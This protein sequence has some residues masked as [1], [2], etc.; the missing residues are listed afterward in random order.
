MAETVISM[1]GFAADPEVAARSPLEDWRERRELDRT[2]RLGPERAAPGL[3]RRP[4]HPR[5]RRRY[6]PCA[7]S[8]GAA[9]Q[10][11]IGGWGTSVFGSYAGEVFPEYSM[12]DVWGGQPDLA[13]K[14]WGIG[15]CP[16][17]RAINDW[18]AEG[19]ADVSRRYPV[20]GFMADHARYPAPASVWS[21]FAC[22]CPDC[23]P[24]ASAWAMT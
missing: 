23:A 2:S 21:M 3:P 16:S 24:K 20:A 12:R 4:R 1:S 17:K 22:A 5:R 14:R 11:G 7:A 13:Y 10:A 9:S 18:V 19:L 6:A 15:F 8:L